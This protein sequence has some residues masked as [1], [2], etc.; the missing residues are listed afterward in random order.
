MTAIIVLFNLQEGIQLEDYE[1]WAKSTDLPIVRGLGSVDSYEVFR[2][3][4]LLGSEAP[5]PYQYIE[6]IVIN[7]SDLFN[8]D[9]SS[10]IMTKVAAE[11]QSFADNPQFLMTDK[12][13]AE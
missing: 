9:I 10:D 8:Q 2:S 3:S 1:R 13:V 12:L 7:D 6:V 4:G 11:F 5:A